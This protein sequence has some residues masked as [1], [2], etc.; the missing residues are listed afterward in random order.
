MTAIIYRSRKF[1]IY[2]KHNDSECLFVISKK[3]RTI[4]RD[5]ARKYISIN[6]GEME[7]FKREKST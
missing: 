7:I 3:R 5:Q 2:L 6:F 1:K 4:K